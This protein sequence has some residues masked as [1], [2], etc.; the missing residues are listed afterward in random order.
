MPDAIGVWIDALQ[1]L[2]KQ[3]AQIRGGGY[4]AFCPSHA[5]GATQGKKSLK[6]DEGDNG[7]ILV[8]CFAGCTFESVRDSLGMG[9]RAPKVDLS[10]TPAPR[11]RR[12]PKA[13]TILAELPSG[14][15]VQKWPYTD[16]EGRIVMVVVRQ[17]PGKRFTQW[18]PHPKGWIGQSPPGLHPA[19][20]LPALLASTGRVA[21]VEGE[22][23]ADTIRRV[24][25]T[26]AV[27]TYSGG[28][29][30][31]KLTDWEPL[32]GR[33]VSLVADADPPD[34]K[35]VYISHKSMTGLADHLLTLGCQVWIALPE[36]GDKSDVTDWIE[37]HGL[38]AAAR[39]VA[40]LLNP[41]E[42]APGTASQGPL[43]PPDEPA[44]P[45]EPPAAPAGNASSLEDNEHYRLL[46]LA[47]SRVVF[48]LKVAGQIERRTREQMVQPA[49]LIS[50][51]PEVWWCSQTGAPE[52][53]GKMS[54][55]SGDALI[56]AADILGQIDVTT[57]FGRGAVRLIDG[58]V[59][60]H[61][62]DRILARGETHSLDWGGM[63]WLA[64]P[65]VPLAKPASDEQMKAVAK[66]LM[67]YRWATPLDGRRTLGWIVAA[68]IGGALEWRPHISLVAPASSG[69]SWLLRRIQTL[70]GPLVLRVADATPAAIA[71][72]TAHTAIPVL[73]DEA[74]PTA[75]WITEVLTLL[76]VSAGGDGMRVR[77]EQGSDGVVRQ[78]AR[79][80]A[81]MSGTS[82]P[83]LGQADASR[84]TAVRLGSAVEDWP[85]VMQSI[86]DAMQHADAVRARIVHQAQSIVDEADKIAV[87]YQGLGM[88][89]REALATASLTAG[90]RAWGIDV[91]DVYS[92]DWGS[93]EGASDSLDLLQDILALRY[94]RDGDD[95]ALIQLIGKDSIAASQ[96]YGVRQAGD[97]IRSGILVAYGHRGLIGALSRTPHS[98]VDLRSMLLQLPGAKATTSARHFGSLKL[99]A[100]EIPG[101]TL[102]AL[103][104]NIGGVNDDDD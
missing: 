86:D 79:F 57:V 90:W 22:K 80:A 29:P 89:S 58:T 66:A 35:G 33:E 11:Q 62:G 16:A 70:M 82:A 95:I 63:V 37:K 39:L 46:G 96:L 97:A 49:T 103:G 47:G 87:E 93:E 81:L 30:N 54:R 45:I 10:A 25:P 23:D 56:R 88:A 24:W 77:A 6:V 101:D 52:V 48:R 42:P 65:A 75:G 40:K 102:R 104:I 31:W 7:T 91:Q 53:G 34:K 5:D 28:G 55:Q 3:P 44:P 26:Q 51:A 72:L 94:R 64:E 76:R 19:Y 41:Y 21:I 1:R 12:E 100:V 92:V 4:M 15:G 71:R 74:E 9:G 60:Y 43:T 84:L 83:R 14:D 36:Y 61:L 8:S 78:N 50:M 85:G 17:D 67:A 13:P 20:Q 73:I 2:G 18:S 59:A 38:E 68:I 69:K 99:R 32:R 98:A 27:T